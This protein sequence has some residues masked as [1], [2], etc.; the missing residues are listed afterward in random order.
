M[1]WREQ[2]MDP[3]R[4]PEKKKLAARTFLFSISDLCTI[5][6]MVW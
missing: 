5:T 4:T 1:A 2:D 3:L 6:P